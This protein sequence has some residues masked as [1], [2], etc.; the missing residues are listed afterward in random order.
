MNL[1]SGVH[2]VRVKTAAGILASYFDSEVAALSAVEH[3]V[4]YKAAWH[5]LNPLAA[6][7]L[8]P[9]TVINP[10][11]L[12][13][14]YNT[15]A[16][17][18]ILRR[19]WL[20]LDFDPPRPKDSNSTDEE[21]TAAH[22]Q[23]EECRGELTA[24]GWP[25]PTVIDSGNGY[26]LR[27]PITLPNDDAS[28]ELVRSVLHALAERHSMLDVTNHN[29]ARVAKLPGTWA[30]KG[31]HTAD[32]PH[33]LST[34][35]EAGGCEVV[36][37][38][39]L[40]A[41]VP[42]T[43]NVCEYSAPETLTSEESKAAREWLLGY[44]EHFE[45]VAR[46][47]ARRITGGWKIG[48]YCP[49][50]ETDDSPHDEG[51]ETSTVISM[52]NGR[53]AFKCAHNTCEKLGRNTATF[54]DAMSLRNPVP[55]LPEPGQDAVAVFGGQNPFPKLLHDDLAHH[56]L[57]G[58]QDF[59]LV[60]DVDPVLL[61]AWTV[62]GWKLRKDKW[63]LHRAI[64]TYLA[65]LF[66]RYPLAKPGAEKKAPRDPRR[67]L[68]GADTLGGVSKIAELF[69]P[70]VRHEQFDTE[71]Y[72]L[73]L[74]NGMV[75][76]LETG[77]VRPMLREDF[78]SQCLTVAPDANCPTPR[79]DRFLQEISCGD[80]EQADYLKGLAALCLNAHPTNAIFA[81]FGEGRNGKSSYLKV[82]EGILGSMARSVR[83]GELQESQFADS[84]N[85]RTLAGF[86]GARMVC[87]KETKAKNL[88]FS[89]L[90]VLT[91]GDTVNGASM[92]QDARSIR[93]T[94][95]L[96]LTTND[97]P[98]FPPDAAFKG[99]VQ[100]VPFGANFSSNPEVTIDATMHAELPGILWGLI[101]LSP[102]VIKG[103]LMR[104]SSV[105][106]ATDELFFELDVAARFQADCLVPAPDAV[107]VVAEVRTVAGRWIHREGLDTDMTARELMRELR[108]RFGKR[109]TIREVEG[110]NTW[111][112][113]G[114]RLVDCDPQVIVSGSASA[115]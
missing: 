64:S 1:F 52:I 85:K 91:G 106:I 54:K 14:T 110:K 29:A 81:L 43:G 93:A 66:T 90:K 105:K 41:L 94:W 68:K 4:N 76:N 57:K 9:D 3:L 26:H 71:E 50:T 37:E 31:E 20:L 13:R 73:G 96:I 8:T 21:K 55:Y 25:L 115:A 82:L 87:S 22:Q 97:A 24:M 33:R 83:P 58:N 48:I 35:L 102:S 62:E 100:L 84:Q 28:H 45:L 79:W 108:K 44:V 103:G 51:A 17:S 63:L 75:A 18:H 23:A 7:A 98:V 46:T 69:L 74:P 109:Y 86:E 72:L 34:L 19:E 49:L 10:A 99:R 36:S 27:Y 11:E 40:R 95:K 47:D 59:F 6:D 61:A 107:A 89:L 32:R 111:V 65:D 16:D 56:F 15:A 67:M 2:E 101:G 53:L 70:E 114:V 12:A 5:T 104:P 112:I 77:E 88:D 30:R 39:Q 78:I 113:T 80:Q 42:Q 60:R 38:A 92:R